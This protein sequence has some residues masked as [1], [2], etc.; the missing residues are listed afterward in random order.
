MH[1]FLKG[2]LIY[3]QKKRISCIECL[4]TA[5][6]L[7][8]L[9]TIDST[10]YNIINISLIYTQGTKGQQSFSGGALYLRSSLLPNAK[11]EG[12]KNLFTH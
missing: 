7:Y 2:I 4:R 5:I 3:P 1:C 6:H 8:I 9:V 10:W 12:E 11:S